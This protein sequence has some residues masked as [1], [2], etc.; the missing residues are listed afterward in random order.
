MERIGPY[1]LL[2]EL[3][4]GGMG[5]VYRAKRGDLD[6]EFALKVISAAE[7][8]PELAERFH[9]EARTAA[10][11]AGTPGIAG[12]HDFGEADGTLYLA[13]D[14]LPGGSLADRLGAQPLPPMEAARLGAA[15]ARAL[16][17]AHDAGTLHRD[18]KP[19]NILFDASGAPAIADFGLARSWSAG[20]DVTRLTQ[21]GTVLGT[22]AYMPPEQALGHPL[23]V[24]ADC[25]ALG[26]TLYECCAG[27]PPFEADSVHGVLMQ[28]LRDRPKPIRARVRAMPGDLETVILKCLEKSPGD[29][30][31]TAAA[32][33]ADLERVVAGEPILARPLGA[34]ERAGRRL[35]A[36]P[37][38]AAAV[39]AIGVGGPALVAVAWT[40]GDGG[41]RLTTAKQ[42]TDLETRAADATAPF[43]ALTTR[44]QSALRV[45]TDHF[46]GAPV[47]ESELRARRSQAERAARE[48]QRAHP[49]SRTPAAW[50]GLITL[51]SDN[52][53][54][55]LAA[56]AAACRA[57]GDDPYPH[58]VHA[59]ARL[60]LYSRDVELTDYEMVQGKL[61]WITDGPNDGVSALTEPLRAAMRQA[62]HC[63]L[64][65]RVRLGESWSAFAEAADAVGQGDHA[66]AALRFGDLRSDPFFST[67]S[68]LLAG[69][70][71]V[72][73]PGR[74]A[75][76]HRAP[77]RRDGRHGGALPQPA[78]AGRRRVVDRPGAAVLH[79]G[80]G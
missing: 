11:L 37:I 59:W 28:T 35:R 20:P 50:I 70:R 29:R 30:Y 74:P 48:Q 40:A 5:V 58:L 7:A 8:T 26:A 27:A 38:A 1:E 23:E 19:D 17:A 42:A 34:W 31:P 75:L 78:A 10:A 2:G 4:R 73:R 18:L 13:M 47:P 57:A 67:E 36:N 25:Y 33:A 14:L 24:T 63:A 76:D 66:G 62:R 15:L 72:R 3:G 80:G 69:T 61:I 39:V 16:Q 45:L 53:E 41:R 21:S 65:P 32:L 77:L 6:R 52:E 68:A 71:R 56:I 12:V 79:R 22:P 49:A 55:G 44:T 43:L 60:A 9:R 51:L 64:W 54:A 46:H